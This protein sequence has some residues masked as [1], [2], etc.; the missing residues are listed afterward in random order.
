MSLEL[1]A[2]VAARGFDVSLTVQ[3]GETVAVLGPN[4]AGK[5]TLLAVIAGLLR[6]DR[7]RAGMRGRTLF[8]IDAHGRGTV[9]PPHRRAVSLLAQEPLLFPH[10]SALENVAFGPRSAG[11]SR[12]DAERTARLWLDRVDAGELAGQRPAQ[13]SGGQAQRI[14]V[15]RALATDPELLL[16]D[17]PLAALDVA[18]APALRRLL[19]EVLADRTAIIVTHDVLDALTLADR[20]VVLEGGRLVADGPTR[21]LLARPATPFTA[22]LAALT[23]LTGTVTAT[24]TGTVTATAPAQAAA[25]R[26][27]ALI[28][29]HAGH[30]IRAV[31]AEPLAPG[32]RVGVAVRPTEVEV[33][34]DATPATPAH[35]G[36]LVV[37]Q[38]TVTDLEPRG[39]LVRVHSADFAADLSPRRVAELDLAPG[40]PVRF[41]FPPT[42][43]SAYPL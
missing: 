38:G 10:L 29:T 30:R 40:T 41:S 37:V 27:L 5:S 33:A 43:A 6:P 28:T 20:A 2:A 32:A 3:P 19:R 8:D 36:D 24:L 34:V 31:L 12:R 17:E 35:P 22:Q 42:A 1:T 15:A 4:G 14:A 21:T 23:L 16:L 11:R 26:P 13:L 18:M 9:L 25:D 39:D 7:G